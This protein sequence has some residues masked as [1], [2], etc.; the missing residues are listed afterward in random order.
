MK[1]LLL[2]L[3]FIT[4]DNLFNLFLIFGKKNTLKFRM[5]LGLLYDIIIIFES[6]PSTPLW[7]DISHLYIKKKKLEKTVFLK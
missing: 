1:S 3:C 4:S 7:E 6:T 2:V 5:H